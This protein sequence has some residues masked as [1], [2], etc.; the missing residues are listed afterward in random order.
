MPIARHRSAQVCRL[1][2]A[3][4]AHGSGAPPGALGAVLLDECSKVV[5]RDE[6]PTADHEGAQF[7]RANQLVERAA[8]EPNQLRC[9]NNR[10]CEGCSYN[11][12]TIVHQNTP[13]AY[14]H[15]AIMN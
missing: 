15:R 5:D 13:D 14:D 1:G 7:A 2:V 8:P 9:F 10:N 12:D 4:S 3:L 6:T 11:R